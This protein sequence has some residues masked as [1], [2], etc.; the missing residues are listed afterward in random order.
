LDLIKRSRIGRS[1]EMENSKKLGIVL[2]VLIL[3]V[4]SHAE[5]LIY[6]KT[7]KGFATQGQGVYDLN[8]QSQVDWRWDVDERMDKGFLILDVEIDPKSQLVEINKATQIEYWKD[9]KKKNYERLSSIFEIDRIEVGDKTYWVL[10]DIF[11]PTESQV[12][13]FMAEGQIRSSNIGFG[14]RENKREIPLELT[15]LAMTFL[16][17]RNEDIE[18]INEE[19][20]IVSLRLHKKWTK[21][22]N[23]YWTTY[24]PNVDEYSPLEWAVGGEDK[25]GQAYGIVEEW[26][27]KRGYNQIN[28]DDDIVDDGDQGGDEG[29]TPPGVILLLP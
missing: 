6:S 9:G 29:D 3:G 14:S 28:Q 7:V 2:A 16:Q 26:L 1:D 24:E 19:I 11:V 18:S 5:I 15:G 23:L 17:D 4:S 20:F 13:V 22:A 12:L 21:M 10:R 25:E 8:D 27:K